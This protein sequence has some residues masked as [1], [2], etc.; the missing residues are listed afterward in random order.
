MEVIVLAM[1][2]PPCL[3][4]HDERGGEQQIQREAREADF[5]RRLGVAQR[6]K[7]ARQDVDRG[8]RDQP[9]READKRE[10]GAFRRGRGERAV[11]KQQ[12]HDG[13]GQHEEQ[14]GRDQVGEQQRS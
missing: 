10:R 1:P 12:P 4:R 7:R 11:L 14:N 9:R 5:H 6:K 2:R 13:F 3:Q 8:E